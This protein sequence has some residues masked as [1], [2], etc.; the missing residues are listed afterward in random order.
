MAEDTA[1]QERARKIGQLVAKAWFDEAFKQRL[2]ANPKA[3]FGELGLE[4][5]ADIDLRVVEDTERISYFV[6]PHKPGK[7][8]LSEEQLAAVAGGRASGSTLLWPGVSS[9]CGI[10]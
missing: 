2:L 3:V 6:L 7:G 10:H 1:R 9:S 8:D 4:V 5:S